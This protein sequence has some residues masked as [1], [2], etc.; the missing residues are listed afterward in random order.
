MKLSVVEQNFLHPKSKAK[1]TLKF[2]IHKPY[3][4]LIQSLLISFV[5]MNH[6]NVVLVLNDMA[7]QFHKS[8]L[9]TEN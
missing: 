6:M 3:S 1:K 7:T 5:S 2:H 8:K 4:P 9:D